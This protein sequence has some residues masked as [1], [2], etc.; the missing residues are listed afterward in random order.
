MQRK[1]REI[2]LGGYWLALFI[3]THIPVPQELGGMLEHNNDKLLHMGV[4]TILAVCWANWRHA[5]GG[6]SRKKTWQGIL[7]LGFYGIAD[8]LI[9]IPTGRS[10]ELKDWLSDMIGIVLGFAIWWGYLNL[11]RRSTEPV[12][13]QST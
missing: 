12:S 2:L 13:S 6:W 10:A 9:Q 8:E 4:Y 5:V 11:F 1:W 3:A 7:L